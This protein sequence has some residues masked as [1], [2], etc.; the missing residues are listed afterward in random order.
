MLRGVRR[1]TPPPSPLLLCPTLIAAGAL[2][3][4]G[5]GPT[6]IIASPPASPDVEIPAQPPLTQPVQV[7]GDPEDTPREEAAVAAGEDDRPGQFTASVRPNEQKQT[8][9]ATPIQ[10]RISLRPRWTARVGKTTFRTTMAQVGGAIVIGTHGAT[11]EGKNEPSDGVHV[12]D[13]K[14]GR[15]RALIAVRGRG[16][17]DVGGIAIDG[18][19]VYFTTDSSQVVAATLAGKVLWQEAMRGKVR[20]AP[21]LA[22]LNGDGKVDVVVG[23]EE[24]VLSALD[25]A[26]GKPIWAQPTGR[27]ESDAQG[28][29]GAAAI[30]D[31]DGDGRD[32]V[33][34]GAR[35][36]FMTAY[37]G[38]DGSPIWQMQGGSGIHASPV[39]LDADGDGRREV[40]AA[41]SYSTVMLLDVRTGRERWSQWVAQDS[42]GIEG[43][44]GTPTPLPG[45]PRGGVLITPTSWWGKEDGVVGVGPDQR[46][47]HATEQR[48]T[49]SAVVTDL[50]GDGVLE[51]LLGTEAGKVLALH[52]DGGRAELAVVRGGVEATPMLADVDADGTYELLVAAGD[53]TLHCFTTGSTARPLIPRFRGESPHNRGEYA[54]VKLGWKLAARG[55]R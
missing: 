25:G 50:D 8:L 51:A 46:D 6:P 45:G 48:V 5:C 49:S 35:D 44:F 13:A 38:V 21:A 3:A 32:D 36:G 30:T 10:L 33:I 15:P 11:L 31:V 17:L 53:G 39:I 1:A 55:R 18:D 37:R 54:G 4:L 34:A 12:L 27:N 22:D 2:A 42:G 20:P 47:F 29:I 16:D 43:L 52:A 9:Q 28:F 14:T 41:W 24:G 40:L 19:R 7:A 26:T 23:D